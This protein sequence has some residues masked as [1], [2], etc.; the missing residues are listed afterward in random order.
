MPVRV[1]SDDQLKAGEDWANVLRTRL[2]DSE[3]F[4]L[5]LTPKTLGSSWVYQELGAAWALGKRIVAVA[6]D[7]HLVDKLPVDVAGLQTISLSEIDKL[8]DIIQR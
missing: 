2:H 6:S 5:L 8:D 1:W 7:E 4:L 3:Y